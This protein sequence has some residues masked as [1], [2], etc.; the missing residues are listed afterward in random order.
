MLDIGFIIWSTLQSDNT[1]T[2]HMGGY[3]L[4]DFDSSSG[5]LGRRGNP[6]VG[7]FRGVTE[8]IAAALAIGWD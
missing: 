7:A 4:D 2:Y 1:I 5:G 8:C 6:Q 3:V